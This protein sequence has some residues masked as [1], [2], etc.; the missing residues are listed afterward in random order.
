MGLLL[1]AGAGA[2]YYIKTQQASEAETTP[3]TVAGPA[4]PATAAAAAPSHFPIE[5]AP[6]APAKPLPTL[7]ESDAEAQAE[8]SGVFS[9]Q[10]LVNLFQLKGLI[11]RVV[12]T[13]D[14]LPRERV[15]GRLLAFNPVPG[16]FAVAG[17][18]GSTSISIGNYSR[19][20]SYATAAQAVDAKKL[21]AI[22]V[23]FYPLFQQAYVDLGYPKGYFNDRLVQAID[24]LLA[25]P[26]PSQPVALEQPNVL[27]VYA[28]PELESLS[29]G[30]KMIL[31]MGPQN[32]AV[33][34]EKLR[35][36]RTEIT[37]SG[38]KH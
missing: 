33:V 6:A 34:E 12:A 37:A 32:A 18:S 27:Y 15:A 19:Y 23:H 3:P 36:I 31:R 5:E 2:I 35:E 30:Q 10:T 16:H 4:A 38:L 13:V 9:Q 14:N 29:A 28:D 11:R 24:N 1:V 7:D 17:Q 8:L 26:T 21:V 25:T 22:Y 20:S